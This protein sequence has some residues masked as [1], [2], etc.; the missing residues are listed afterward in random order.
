MTP[1]IREEVERLFAVLN[2]SIVTMS[3][4][5]DPDSWDTVWAI[6]VSREGRYAVCNI[7][8]SRNIVFAPDYA[9]GGSQ[10]LLATAITPGGMSKILKWTSRITA[11]QHF[12]ELMM[13]DPYDSLPTV[14]VLPQSLL[15]DD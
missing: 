7:A 11:M 3:P 9:A 8:P 6:L 15:R 12:R 2:I 5:R 4:V 10:G 1:E 13:N 14:S